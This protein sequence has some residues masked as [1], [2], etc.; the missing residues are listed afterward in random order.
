MNLNKSDT[1]DAQLRILLSRSDW[2][3][4]LKLLEKK[5]YQRK[6]QLIEAFTELVASKG[7]HRVKHGDVAKKCGVTRQLVD[8]H[9][10]DET[11]LVTLAYRYIYAGFQKAAADGI[12]ARKGF[13]DQFHG[14]IDAIASWVDEKRVHAQFLVQFYALLQLSPEFSAIQQ[15]NLVIGR[16]RITSLLAIAQKEGV[17]RGASDE[18]LVSAA[19]SLQTYI[20]GFIVMNSWK[21]HGSITTTERQ[22]FLRRCLAVLEIRLPKGR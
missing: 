13:L 11:T 7:L 14:Y 12:M 1:P 6:F 16:E 8:H 15:R 3:D 22:E 19:K 18:Q 21:R 5:S 10:P 17:I 2:G 9:F 4:V 20:L